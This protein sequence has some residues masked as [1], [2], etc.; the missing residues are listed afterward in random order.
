VNVTFGLVGT[1]LTT[2]RYTSPDGAAVSETTISALADT[3]PITAPS[4]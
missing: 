3:T 1:A 4:A 2:I